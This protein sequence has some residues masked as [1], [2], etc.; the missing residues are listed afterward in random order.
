MAIGWL[1][2]LQSVPWTDV[3][4]NA[5]KV[6]AGAKK[7]WNAVGKSPPASARPAPDAQAVLSPDAQAVSALALRIQQ[8]ETA[9]ADLQ[10]QMIASSGLIKALAEQNTQLILRIETLRS[11]MGWLAGALVAVGLVAAASMVLLLIR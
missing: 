9:A 10:A 7:L 6:A 4:R 5:P 8:L 3:V 11:R 2:V 1:T